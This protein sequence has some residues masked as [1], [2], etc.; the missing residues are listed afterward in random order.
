[1]LH[2]V[3]PKYSKGIWSQKRKGLVIL[4]SVFWQNHAYTTQTHIH[5]HSHTHTHTV[6]QINAWVV[7]PVSN[8][9][10]AFVN[11][12]VYTQPVADHID[13]STSVCVSV[14]VCVCVCCRAPRGRPLA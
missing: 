14:C 4:L 1:M 11:G 6:T 12:V 8:P 3:L 13:H 10:P 5:T 7:F 2:A 9:L